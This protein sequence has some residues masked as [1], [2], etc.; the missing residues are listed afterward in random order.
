MN[1]TF[2]AE[3]TLT[4]SSSGED[5]CLFLSWVLCRVD[6]AVGIAVSVTVQQLFLIDLNIPVPGLTLVFDTNKLLM[7]DVKMK[8]LW[9]L[10]LFRL[11]FKSHL[12]C[13]RSWTIIKKAAFYL[14]KQALW[15]HTFSVIW[16]N[17]KECDHCHLVG[18][19]LLSERRL[20]W[21]SHCILHT[22]VGI[23]SVSI[24]CLVFFRGKVKFRGQILGHEIKTM[25]EKE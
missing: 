8:F 16:M 5:I 17:A 12:M 4:S 20:E 19:A 10:F 15:G 22:V 2:N 21:L 24:L 11:P 3:L 25:L 9:Q 1:F 23:R 6:P 18:R 13:F 7:W 14:C